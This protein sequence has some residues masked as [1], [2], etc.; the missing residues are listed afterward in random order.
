MLLKGSER[1]V[2]YCPLPPPPAHPTFKNLHCQLPPTRHLIDNLIHFKGFAVLS[3]SSSLASRSAVQARY[4][5]A[6]TCCRACA[7]WWL[8]SVTPVLFKR[9]RLSIPTEREVLF[10]RKRPFPLRKREAVINT[11]RERSQALRCFRACA[12]WWLSSVAP[13]L[14]VC[15]RERE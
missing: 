13:V 15:E 9:E 12:V 11:N 7:D 5:Q 3:R 1:D 2:F 8:G 14:C 10:E 6:V 4:R